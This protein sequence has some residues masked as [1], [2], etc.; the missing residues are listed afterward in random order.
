[1]FLFSYFFFFPTISD[2]EGYSETF[3]A[4]SPVLHTVRPTF[5][6]GIVILFIV[7]NTVDTVETQN[8]MQ[9]LQ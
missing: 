9:G 4:T 8:P 5:Y 6:K 2:D 1:M 7:I 3:F